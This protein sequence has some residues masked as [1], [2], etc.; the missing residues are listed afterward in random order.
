[1]KNST[2]V[3]TGVA[4]SAIVAVC[5]FT[6]VLVLLLGSI[7][8]SAWLGWLDYILLPALAIFLG[9][10]VYGLWRCRGALACRL[11]KS[12]DKTDIT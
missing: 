10:S 7:G 2:I 6:P 11:Q 3:K 9:A 12:T 1:M 5:C 4:G 8:L